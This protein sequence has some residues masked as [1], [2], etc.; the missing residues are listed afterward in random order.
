MRTF[1]KMTLVAAVAAMVVSMPAVAHAG[2]SLKF[3]DASNNVMTIADG[4]VGDSSV[5]TGVINTS[6]VSFG[7]FSIT[8]STA[9][10]KPFVG[11]SV[12]PLLN[13]GFVV[14]R[15]SPSLGSLTIE[16]SDDGFTASPN[17]LTLSTNGG[18]PSGGTQ[19]FSASAGGS[20]SASIGFGSTSFG[21]SGGSYALGIKAVITS[22]SMNISNGF[23]GLTS[24]VPEPAS[25]AVWGLGALGMMVARKRRQSK[26]VA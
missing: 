15:L 16:V 18:N 12:N 11:S 5:A 2:F 1:F 23:A 9:S 22:S 8:V 19:T 13:L 20:N 26:L 21:Y 6:G 14:S 7:G 3:T 10:S 24:A 25:M 17:W 4:G